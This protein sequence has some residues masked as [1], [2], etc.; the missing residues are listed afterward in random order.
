M[1]L[2]CF[3]AIPVHPSGPSNRLQHAS[4]PCFSMGSVRIPVANPDFSSLHAGSV[5]NLS[6]NLVLDPLALLVT[7]P[8]A[9]PDIQVA[10]IHQ[11]AV[12]ALATHSNLISAHDRLISWQAMLGS[13][14]VAEALLRTDFNTASFGLFDALA[15]GARLIKNSSDASIPACISLATTLHKLLLTCKRTQADVFSLECTKCCTAA[16]CLYQEALDHK[17]EAF[18]AKHDKKHPM[19]AHTYTSS[20]CSSPP[21]YVARHKGGNQKV[22]GKELARS[23][24]LPIFPNLPLWQH[25][26]HSSAIPLQQLAAVV[27]LLVTNFNNWPGAVQLG[28]PRQIR[29]WALR[30]CVDMNTELWDVMTKVCSVPHQ[31]SLTTEEREKVVFVTWGRYA[32]E[33]YNGRLLPG[34]CNPGCTNLAGNSESALPTQL[35]SGCRRVRYC[36]SECQQAAWLDGGHSLLCGK[37]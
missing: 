2:P 27:A 19:T 20:V 24:S 17:V 9:T 5:S 1:L 12:S 18:C 15:A 11:A 8:M 14:V 23:Q 36:T 6:P 22:L 35:C 3:P 7:H 21:N 10:S 30:F 28:V 37:G 25:D 4:T 16:V 26:I 34:C 32:M 13:V 31:T 29:C 33:R